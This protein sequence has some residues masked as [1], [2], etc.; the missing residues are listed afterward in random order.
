MCCTRILNPSGRIHHNTFREYQKWRH[1]EYPHLG[2]TESDVITE[3]PTI[4]STGYI[5][6]MTS[7]RNSPSHGDSRTKSMFIECWQLALRISILKFY[8]LCSIVDENIKCNT[9]GSCI[10]YLFILITWLIISI[11]RAERS[12]DINR[13]YTLDSPLFLFCLGE[14]VPKGQSVKLYSRNKVAYLCSWLHNSL[15][16]GSGEKRSED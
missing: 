16:S 9:F 5:R 7:Y 8:L 14:T 15:H 3:S 1:T 12:H 10:N 2:N 13:I 4:N 6:L 11:C